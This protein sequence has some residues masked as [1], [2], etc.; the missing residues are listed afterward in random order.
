MKGSIVKR[1]IYAGLGALGLAGAGVAVAMSLT[2]PSDI[3]SAVVTP[4][5]S[6]SP[7]ASPSASASPSQGTP[8]PDVTTTPS[9]DTKPVEEPT[10][11]NIVPPADLDST[12]PVSSGNSLVTQ[13]QESGKEPV[14]APAQESKTRADGTSYFV[15]KT[16]GE[17]VKPVQGVSSGAGENPNPKPI[18]APGAGSKEDKTNV[19]TSY[20]NH[21]NALYK[22]DWNEA[23]RY[24]ALTNISATDCAAKLKERTMQRPLTSGYTIVNVD[25]IDVQGNKA[26]MSPIA[27]KNSA[28]VGTRGIP[29]TRSATDP[30]IWLV[31]IV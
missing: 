12:A 16:T 7:S 25:P 5:Y 24:V 9:P 6:V 3:A 10:V 26:T 2:P 1:Y 4:P 22:Q 30:S 28:G 8:S 31:D 19:A 13:K 23:C 21:L 18:D 15:D 20:M 29:L 17:E 14:L 11:A 27:L